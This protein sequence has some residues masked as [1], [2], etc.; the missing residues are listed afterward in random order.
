MT[1][2]AQLRTFMEKYTP[3]IRSLANAALK[4]MRA[5]LPGAF[6]L[7]YD[8]YNALV[9]GFGPTERSSEAIF[10]I[11]LY[12]RW[13]TLFFLTGKGL[14]DPERLLKGDGVQVRH[15][16]LESVETLDRPAI[17]ALMKAALER[18]D[19]IPSKQR[20]HLLIKSISAKQRPRRPNPTRQ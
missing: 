10:S 8:N 11:V 3:E 2:E 1:P 4:K 14:P 18:S 9:V 19:P 20:R 15:V 12:P 6:E 5:R 17:Q 16:V 13:V 7:V